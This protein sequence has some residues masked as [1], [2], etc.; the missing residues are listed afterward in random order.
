M[1]R[2]WSMQYS[3][4]DFVNASTLLIVLVSLQPEV[5]AVWPGRECCQLA[6]SNRCKNAC[7]RVSKHAHSPY[8]S[9]CILLLLVYFH[10]CRL[11][12]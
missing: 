1:M 8:F 4:R 9:V 7:K 3:L 2:S 12:Y 6:W 10:R 11:N 5:D